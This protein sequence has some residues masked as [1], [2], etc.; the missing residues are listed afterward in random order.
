[1]QLYFI[2]NKS[3]ETLTRDTQS[4]NYKFLGHFRI[5]YDFFAYFCISFECIPTST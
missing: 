1:M 5:L 4:S 2:I 3:K